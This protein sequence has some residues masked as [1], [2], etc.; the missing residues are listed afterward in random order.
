M[1][2]SDQNVNGDY[3][4]FDDPLTQFAAM[5]EDIKTANHSILLQ[6]YKFANDAIGEKFKV[7]L[8]KKAK[9]GI[10]VVLLIDSWG[11]SVSEKFFSEMLSYGGR[12][13]FFK[14]IK[15]SFDFFTANHRRNH[16]KILII[17]E[18]ITYIGSSNI[19]NYCINWRESCLR[20]K[21][22]I[23]KVFKTIF[24]EDYHVSN[25]FYKN[26]KN[27]SSKIKHDDFEIIRDIP[28]TRVQ[29][30]RDKFLKLIEKAK[31]SITIETPY[32]L[33]GS[34]I[35]K[36]ILDA[37]NR[38]VKIRIIIPLNSDVR[39]FD[40]LRNKYL[41]QH[42][43]NGVEIVEYTPNNLHA[44]VFLVDDNKFVMGSSNFD[45]RSFRFMHEINLCGK[46]S[47][48][49]SLIKKHIGESASE[50]IPFNYEKWENRR[51]STKIIERLLVPL[52]HF[53]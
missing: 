25:K 36:A 51:L 32:F 44:K 6:T 39:L 13:K 46:N 41:G 43:K 22:S 29:P 40:I 26:K 9:Q 34:S 33:P 47:E 17:D 49:I 2:L 4:M 48:I 12:V 10:K 20:M 31:I 42:H 38:G 27:L 50:S 19:T 15:F 28:S 5:I 53:F 37:I 52:R 7:E 1:K 35:R 21:G 16:R 11:T 18:Q 8:T 45:Y 3:L 24:F 30:T 14:K 23:A